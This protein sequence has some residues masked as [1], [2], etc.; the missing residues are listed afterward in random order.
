MY[1]IVISRVEDKNIICILENGVLTEKYEEQI[2]K[3]LEGNIYVG[4]VE[5]VL[6]KMQVAFVNIGEEKNAF[7]HLKDV[8]PK[9]DE[10]LEKNNQQNERINSVLKPGMP[11]LVQIKRDSTNQKG[12]RISTHIN[13]PGKYIVFL[14]N[15]SFI[16]ISQKIED[17]E[18]KKRLISYV[19]N[20]LP[21]GTGAIIRTAAENKEKDAIAQDLND[22]I[23]KWEDIISQDCSTYP[24]II[25]HNDSLIK[26]ILIDLIEKKIDTVIVDNEENFKEIQEIIKEQGKTVEVKKVSNAI[27][28][29]GLE[30]KIEKLKNR[31]VWLNCGGF[32][33]IDKT[34]A[35]TAID[36]NSGKYDGKTDLETTAYTVNLEATDEIAKQLKLRDIGGIIIVDYID[37]LDNENKKKIQDRMLQNLK[38][39][40]AK[41][42]VE[43]FTKLNLMELTRKHICNNEE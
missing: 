42:Q 3:R 32:I 6:K 22:L 9:V 19:E 34:E 35:L 28:E 4:K 41:T 29:E 11:I 10:K 20:V 30:D 17:E 31:N 2:G 8:L 26:K 18:E 14:P 40:R 43:G 5:N 37:M 23:K 7:I 38:A 21:D 25:Y 36:V 13:L 12:A 24:Q 15:S 39:D 27:E 33:T 16:T 1:S